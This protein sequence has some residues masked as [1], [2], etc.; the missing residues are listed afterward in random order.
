MGKSSADISRNMYDEAKRYQMLVH[1]QGVPWVEADENDRNWIVY[2]LLRRFIQ[3]VIGNGSPDE[4]FKIVGTGAANDFA[5]TGGDGTV[6][7]A[8][9][10]LVEGFQCILPESRNYKGTDNL[11]C[12]PVSTGLTETVLTDSAAD[13][14]L[15]G[16][17]NNLV[18]RTLVPDIAQPGLIYTITANTQTSITVSGNM[19]SDGIQVGTHYRVELST[20]AADRT[21]EVYID[22]YLDEID[23]DEDPELKHTLGMQIETQRRLKLIQNVLV[24]EGSPTPAPYTDS[25]GNQH[26]TLKLATI[27][28]YAGQDIINTTDVTDERPILDGGFWDLWRE[29]VTARGSAASLNERLEAGHGSLVDADKL[30]GQ[31][32]S[33]Y[34]DKFGAWVSRNSDTVYQAETDGLVCAYHTQQG[35]NMSAYTDGSN[36]PTTERTRWHGS[37]NPGICMPVKKGNYWKVTEAEHVWWLPLGN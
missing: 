11:E 22:C 31:E 7:G 17:D 19:L 9:R 16:P 29:V 30:D 33:Y 32:G 15:G 1:Q 6:E 20:P 5:I 21:D 14:T 12:A 2:N 34:S 18:G 37:G 13:F 4:G 28:R 3:K 35:H 8:G 27:Q 26:Y 24:A 23:S 36:P 10:L 25:D